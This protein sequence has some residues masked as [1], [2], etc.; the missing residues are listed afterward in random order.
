MD[1]F[2]L[3]ADSLLVTLI[4]A[5]LWELFGGAS[6]LRRHDEQLRRQPNMVFSQCFTHAFT[7]V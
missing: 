2:L 3:V 5:S 7:M 4:S 6:V 1:I